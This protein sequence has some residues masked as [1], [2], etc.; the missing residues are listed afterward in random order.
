MFSLL[1]IALQIHDRRVPRYRAGGPAPAAT[2]GTIAHEFVTTM[3]PSLLFGA[4]ATSF[5][6]TQLA[7]L[8]R[9]DFDRIVALSARPVFPDQVTPVKI[10]QT[11][12]S[13]WTHLHVYS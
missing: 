4:A 5:G 6:L 13:H 2:F 11:N 9:A 8:E 3:A 1:R 12:I 7:A 10:L